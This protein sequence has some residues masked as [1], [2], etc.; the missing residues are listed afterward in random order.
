MGDK[1]EEI[2]KQMN[3]GEIETEEG[4]DKLCDLH[5]VIKCEYRKCTNDAEFHYCDDC[6][7]EIADNISHGL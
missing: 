3:H 1:I 7:E 4:I 2:V 6:Y 5:S